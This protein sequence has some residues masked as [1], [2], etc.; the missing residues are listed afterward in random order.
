VV[1][2]AVARVVATV[3]ARAGEAVEAMVQVAVELEAWSCLQHVG[4]RH[5]VHERW[6]E[7]KSTLYTPYGCRYGWWSTAM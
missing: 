7:R 5:R 3:A 4:Q 2:G 1:A 6:Q